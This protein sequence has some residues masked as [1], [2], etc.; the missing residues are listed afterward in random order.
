MQCQPLSRYRCRRRQIQPDRPGKQPERHNL[1]IESEDRLSTRIPTR[2]TLYQA[3][4]QGESNDS[5]QH[6]TLPP[7][8]RLLAIASSILNKKVDGVDLLH[9]LVYRTRYI[10]VIFPTRYVQYCLATPLQRGAS[11]GFRIGTDLPPVLQ[12]TFQ[13]IGVVTWQS[14][15]D[16]FWRAEAM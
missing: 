14:F 2:E 12:Y 11:L 10:V 16:I 1:G 15:A 8:L 7:I 4:Q 9:S 3:D 13:K 6:Q 5:S